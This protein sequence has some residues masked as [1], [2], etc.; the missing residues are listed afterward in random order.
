[1]VAKDFVMPLVKAVQELNVE[2]KQ[3]VTELKS[4]NQELF[5]RIERLEALLQDDKK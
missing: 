2:L 1:L 4:E 5:L 3:K